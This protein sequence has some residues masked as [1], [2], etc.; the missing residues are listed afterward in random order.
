MRALAGAA[1]RRTWTGESAKSLTERTASRRGEQSCHQI[2]EVS[3][4]ARD[5]TCRARTAK[6]G[7]IEHGGRRGMKAECTAYDIVASTERKRRP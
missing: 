5:S 3:R 4:A 6:L 1:S 2:G 7:A